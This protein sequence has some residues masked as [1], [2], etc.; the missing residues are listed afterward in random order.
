MYVDGAITATEENQIATKGDYLVTRESNGAAMASTDYSGVAVNNF[1]GN[2]SIAT[3]TADYTG[4]WRISDTA[5]GTTTTFTNI[6]NFAN[7]WYNALT[8]TT[9]TGPDGVLSNISLLELS[10]VVYNTTAGTETV[11]GYYHKSGSDWFGPISVVNSQFDLGSL[12]LNATDIATLNALTASDLVYY[13]T[14]YNTVID[15]SQNQPL[16]T[17]EEKS[18]LHNNDIFAWDATNAKATNVCRPTLNNTV[19]TAQVDSLTGA[20]SYAWKSGGSGAICCYP[21]RACA[22]AAILIQEGCDGYVPD[23]A[24]IIIENEVNYV[25]GENR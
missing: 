6:S 3:I 5:N 19:L 18:D 25:L 15:A 7:T 14:V 24:Q 17:R 1:D 4:E 10:N 12:V 20:V 8:R 13:N 16:L 9:I 21:S 2:G 22:N 11:V 23:N